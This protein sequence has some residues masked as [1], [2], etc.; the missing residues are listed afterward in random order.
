MDLATIVGLIAFV[1]TLMVGVGNH[2]AL[3]VDVPALLVVFGGGLGLTMIALPLESVVGLAGVIKQT[4][5][6]RITPPTRVIESA[7]GMAEGARAGG[8]LSLENDL[9]A[10]NHDPFLTSGI[11]LAIDGTEPDLIMDI[12]ETEVQFIEERHKAAGEAMQALG[13]NG[14]VLGVIAVLMGFIINQSPDNGFSGD[15]GLLILPLLYGVIAW[16][17][18]TAAT[19]KLKVHSVKEI[20]TKR[21]A[22]EAVMSIQSGDNP[23]IVEHKLSVFLAPA[24]RPQGPPPSD[25]LPAPSF[26]KDPQLVAAVADRLAAQPDT[27]FGFDDLAHLSDGD[28][29]VLL[30]A[31]DQKD[32]VLALLAAHDDVSERLLSGMSGRVR[33]F[34]TEEMAFIDDPDVDL[35]ADRQAAIAQQARNMAREGKIQLPE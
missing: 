33:V 27:D 12:L 29:H 28:V 15:P 35:I 5:V 14:L 16:G 19:H 21:L 34:I 4:L 24:Q 22:I 32:L 31:V 7:V 17:L 9:H 6:V 25:N 20:L 8:I 2:L 1:T 30:R 23:R 18:A 13:R 11:M 26:V 10:Q 3:F